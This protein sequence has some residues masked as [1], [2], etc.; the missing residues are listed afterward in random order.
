MSPHQTRFRLLLDEMHPSR[1]NFPL[2]N[3]HH[4]LKHIFHDFKLS[5]IKDPRV[6][7]IAKNEGRILI[8]KNEKHMIELCEEEKVSLICVTERTPHEEI[9]LK[10]MA[11]LKKKRNQDVFVYKISHSPRK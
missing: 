1:N 2:L 3:N 4:D 9:D 7:S 8:S 11:Y 5:G 10:I 6:V